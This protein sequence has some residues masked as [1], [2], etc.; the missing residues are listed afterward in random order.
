M[1]AANPQRGWSTNE[2]NEMNLA[3]W[4]G[5]PYTVLS[6]CVDLYANVF[7]TLSC[8]LGLILVEHHTWHFCN[9]QNIRH[10]TVHVVLTFYTSIKLNGRSSGIIVSI[11]TLTSSLHVA[12]NANTTSSRS[13]IDYGRWTARRRSGRTDNE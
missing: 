11:F 3:H 4:R 9:P 8:T 6:Y 7:A 13:R 1:N 10:F 2:L 5:R 12:Y